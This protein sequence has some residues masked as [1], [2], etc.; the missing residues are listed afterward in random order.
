MT[1]SELENAVQ[2]L[3]R[4]GVEPAQITAYLIVGHPETEAQEIERSMR[5]VHSMGIRIMLSEYSPIPGT[6]DGEKCREWVNLDEPL[7]HNKTAFSISYLGSERLQSLKD[8]S[9]RLN[10]ELP[11]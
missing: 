9:T 4:A 7:F 5:I 8:L 3:R 11:S 6:P 1:S 10:S 2:N